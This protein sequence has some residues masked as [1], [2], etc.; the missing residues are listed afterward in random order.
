MNFLEIK[1]CTFFGYVLDDLTNT[2]VVTSCHVQKHATPH[3]TDCYSPI[4]MRNS[5]SIK[6]NSPTLL[7]EDV[8]NES[9]GVNDFYIGKI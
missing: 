5:H 9:E 1:I 8:E 4:C 2:V 6:L 3:S 7:I